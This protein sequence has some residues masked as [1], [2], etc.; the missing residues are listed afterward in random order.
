FLT[1]IFAKIF[2][3][4]VGHEYSEIEE[5]KPLVVCRIDANL[6]EI[7]WPRIPGAHARPFFASLL[8]SK[9][10][11]G[12]APQ[13]GDRTESAFITLDDRHD[14][15]W[16]AGTD[17]QPNA[18]GLRRQTAAKFLPGCTAIGALKNS[19]DVLAAVQAWARCETPW[20]SLSRVKRSK[21]DL[22]IRWVN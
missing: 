11:A 14:N 7:K 13:I 2:P 16:I 8:R 12:F 15:L 3:T 18:A 9:D 6:T 21:N 17:R 1:E 10:A 20:R 22:W 5:I 19:T 4:V